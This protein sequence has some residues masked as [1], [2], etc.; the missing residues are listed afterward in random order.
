MRA[1]GHGAVNGSPAVRAS[2][3]APAS[4]NAVDSLARALN[5]DRARPRSAEGRSA[6]GPVPQACAGSGC[7]GGG[8]AG[9]SCMECCAG[10]A[11]LQVAPMPPARSNQVRS[12]ELTRARKRAFPRSHL[13]V[14]WNGRARQQQKR[15][16][17]RETLSRPGYRMRALAIDRPRAA[18]SSPSNSESRRRSVEPRQRDPEQS[19]ARHGGARF[20]A[21][22]AR[23]VQLS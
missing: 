21:D 16:V 11:A 7:A 9:G 5:N 3:T 13:L 18:L 19:I 14:I 15:G 8:G 1:R 20:R 6:H 10:V 23:W 2:S 17:Q 4:P 22:R 12:A